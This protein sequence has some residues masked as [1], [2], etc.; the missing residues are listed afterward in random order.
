LKAPTTNTFDIIIVGAGPAGTACALALKDSGLKVA[1]L[2]K[3][4]FPRDKVC[5]DAI[6]SRVPKVLRSIASE[7]ADEIK[8]FDKKINTRGCRVVA[9]NLQHVDIFFKLDGYISTRLDF[10]NKMVEIMKKFSSITFFENTPATDIM[11]TE[12][13]VEIKSEKNIFFNSKLVIGCDGAHSVIEKK[14]TATKMDPKHYT[15]AVR[16][17]YKNISDTENEMMEIH[18]LKEYPAA[19]LWIFPLQNKMANVGFGMLS[20]KISERKV[21][22]RKSLLDIVSSHPSLSKRFKNAEAMDE[23][24]GYGLPMGSRRVKISGQRFMLCGDA[25]SLIDPATGEGIGNAMI[26]GK[27]AAEQAIKCFQQNNFSETFM[28]SY[29]ENLFQSIGKELKQKYFIQRTLGERAWLA[30]AAITLA[31]KNTFVKKW[32]QKMF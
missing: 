10:D 4:K 17:Y 6:P 15:G 11:I 23:V 7:I 13:G 19:Y 26:S 16:A 28:K 22:L 29:D 25:A 5:G 21:N 3:H 32:L 2:D 1:V 12:E 31:S 24:T 27:F 20:E 30:N 18:L 9:P 14:I 8:S